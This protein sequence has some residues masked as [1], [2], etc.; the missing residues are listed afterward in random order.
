[1]ACQD[2]KI[3]GIPYFSQLVP[4]CPKNNVRSLPNH[5]Q[6]SVLSDT[7]EGID[8]E[9]YLLPQIHW[10]DGRTQSTTYWTEKTH[11]P[12]KLLY[13]R[14]VDDCFGVKVRAFRS[15]DR[16]QFEPARLINHQWVVSWMRGTPKSSI[17]V[18]FAI[19]SHLFLGT[20]ILG[21]LQLTEWGYERIYPVCKSMLV[22]GPCRGWCTHSV[23]LL[24]RQ[25][26]KYRGIHSSI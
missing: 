21:N 14:R 3:S 18:G 16:H 13:F 1:M 10:L 26:Q 6:M 7:F 24:S 19:I 25:F 12:I 11:E 15:R 9:R 23:S 22:A 20:P 17:L 5:S 4:P 8:C 2:K